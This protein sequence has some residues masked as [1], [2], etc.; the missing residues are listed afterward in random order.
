M[1]WFTSRLAPQERKAGR[2]LIE[3][4]QRM[5]AYQ[6]LS[7]ER[8]NDAVAGAAGMPALTDEGLRRPVVALTDTE[9]IRE[10]V[11]PALRA[12]VEILRE[13]QEHHGRFTRPTCRQLRRAYDDFSHALSLLRDR[14]DLQSKVF[15]SFLD[16]SASIPDTTQVDA[17]ELA[18]MDRA[19]KTLNELIASVGIDGDAWMELNC[20]AF[21]AVRKAVGLGPLRLQDFQRTFIGGLEGQPARYFDH[22]DNATGG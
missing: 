22:P 15:S 10:R 19:L 2:E 16:H 21:N 3:H 13:M 4:I 1:G 5:L 7:M 6:Q 12:K 14:A 20:E 11:V 9:A 8:Y 17:A 18:A